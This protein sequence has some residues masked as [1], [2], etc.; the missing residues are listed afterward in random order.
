MDSA[1]LRLIQRRVHIA[2]L[3]LT[4]QKFDTSSIPECLGELVGLCAT[5]DFFASLRKHNDLD[6]DHCLPLFT[7]FVIG[8]DIKQERQAI[9][10]NMSAPWFLL[11]ASAHSKL[12]G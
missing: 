4:K 12:A 5:E 11:N 6:D 3:D 1:Q 2:Q 7:A 9:H 10:I 8:I